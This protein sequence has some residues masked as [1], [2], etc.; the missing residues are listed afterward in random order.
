[1]S[2]VE[3]KFRK[4]VRATPQLNEFRRVKKSGLVPIPPEFDVRAEAAASPKAKTIWDTVDEYAK[5]IIKFHTLAKE[6]PRSA[7]SQSLTP[8]ALA[9]ADLILEDT[10]NK[11]YMVRDRC[12][13][14]VAYPQFYV[15]LS[16]AAERE[17]QLYWIC[18]A[19]FRADAGNEY[20][21]LKCGDYSRFFTACS[22]YS[23]ETA[24]LEFEYYSMLKRFAN[25][26]KFDSEK[27]QKVFSLFLDGFDP[28]VI[29]D[30]VGEPLVWVRKKLEQLKTMC[31]NSREDFLTLSLIE[32]REEVK[33]YAEEMGIEQV[34]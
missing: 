8:N 4:A 15:K 22:R 11:V 2:L 29:S 30:F 28:I 17:L 7:T 21:S 23:L 18:L 32:Q 27:D 1:M 12:I 14:C 6:A 16:K 26:F 24:G 19:E 5:D 10:L 9:K 20:Y 31:E 13:H 25:M 33:E 3:P 34:V